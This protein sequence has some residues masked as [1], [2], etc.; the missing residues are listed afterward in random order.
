MEAVVWL[1]TDTAGSVC[2]VWK[3][4]PN[5]LILYTAKTTAFMPLSLLEES[6]WFTAQVCSTSSSESSMEAVVLLITVSL[7]SQNYC[8]HATFTA[9]SVC[10][11]TWYSGKDIVL[12]FWR[13]EPLSQ[14][15]FFTF[16][17]HF[18]AHSTAILLLILLQTA[19]AYTA[20]SAWKQ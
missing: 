15:Q 1:C 5:H 13:V 9:R 18:T 4:D 6:D 19:T 12:R 14:T 17:W 11:M 10:N 8:F 7:H 2:D 3:C 20:G 16:Y